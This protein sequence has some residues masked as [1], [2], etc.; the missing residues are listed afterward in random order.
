[1]SMDTKQMAKHTF[2]FASL[3]KTMEQWKAIVE[4]G[5]MGNDKNVLMHGGW[6]Y[7]IG[8]APQFVTGIQWHEEY[9]TNRYISF[10]KCV[11]NREQNIKKENRECQDCVLYV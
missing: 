7:L 1:M 6:R 5:K 8:A 4:F 3:Q 2:L 11:C 10:W 9:S